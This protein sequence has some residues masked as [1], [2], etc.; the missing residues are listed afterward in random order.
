M[1]ARMLE[2]WTRQPGLKRKAGDI[3]GMVVAAA[4]QPGFYGPGRAADTPEGRLELV[5]LHL[6]LVA[7]RIKAELPDGELLA[8]LLIEAFVTDMD[9]CMREMGVGD[10]TVPKRVKSAAAMF[11]ERGGDYRAALA[12]SA[13]KSAA[14]DQLV[15]IVARTILAGAGDAALAGE[16]A[17]YIRT[18]HDR[19]ARVS[20]D[21]LA[22][23]QFT[24]GDAPIVRAAAI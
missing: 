14:A 24:F 12:N 21:A 1:L 18:A 17:A 16:L 2:R 10:L 4:R 11:Y 23:G 7:E 8:Q 19:L 20:I 22:A 13:Q 3:Y 15:A 6:F 5:A 9:D